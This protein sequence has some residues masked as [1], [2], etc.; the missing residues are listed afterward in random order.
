MGFK[1]TRFDLDVWIRGREGGYNYIGNN[2]DDILVVALKP[3]SIFEK[4]K[5][6]YTIKTFVP[7]T[8]HLGCDYARITKGSENK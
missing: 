3:T 8:V 5:E 4:L 2:T 1:P 6:T 7:P